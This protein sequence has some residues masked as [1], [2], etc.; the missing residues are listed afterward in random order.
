MIIHSDNPNLHPFVLLEVQHKT[1]QSKWCTIWNSNDTF[2]SFHWHNSKTHLKYYNVIDRVKCLIYLYTTG[3]TEHV[4]I[5]SSLI[6]PQHTTHFVYD[7]FTLDLISHKL[8]GTRIREMHAS[9]SE[10]TLRCTS[11]ESSWIAHMQMCSV[12]GRLPRAYAACVSLNFL[13]FFPAAGAC[14]IHEKTFDSNV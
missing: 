1:L 7:I 8:L 6:R 9:E 13:E 14:T 12:K 3:I 10:K 2:I 5:G 4:I 11:H